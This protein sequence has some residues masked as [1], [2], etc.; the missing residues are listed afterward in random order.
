MVDGRAL[1]PARVTAEEQSASTTTWRNAAVELEKL[2]SGGA[3]R[4]RSTHS[5]AVVNIAR[6]MAEGRLVPTRK[7]TMFMRKT[8]L[9]LTNVKTLAAIIIASQGRLHANGLRVWDQVAEAHRKTKRKTQRIRT[10]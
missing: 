6:T 2:C 1:R 5:F 7:S 10:P 9:D 4:D 3:R 8:E